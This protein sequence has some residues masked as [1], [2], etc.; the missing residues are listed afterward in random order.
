MAQVG[1][2]SLALAFIV[3]LYSIVASL[4]GIRTCKNNVVSL[5]RNSLQPTGCADVGSVMFALRTN[6]AT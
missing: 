5:S 1:Q 4:V 2:F 6:S 3:A